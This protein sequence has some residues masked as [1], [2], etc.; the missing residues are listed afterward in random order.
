MI[1]FEGFSWQQIKFYIWFLQSPIRVECAKIESP[2]NIIEL[3]DAMHSAK[4]KNTSRGYNIYVKDTFKIYL[5]FYKILFF[6]NM[7]FK[8]QTKQFI[9]K[10]LGFKEYILASY[11][12]IEG[13]VQ[14]TS[15]W[16]YT[17]VQWALGRVTR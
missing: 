14:N 7:C 1:W 15:Q 12:D 9:K 16:H 6:A 3:K 10:A 13:A 5:K 8:K 4:G 17:S 11:L 2:I